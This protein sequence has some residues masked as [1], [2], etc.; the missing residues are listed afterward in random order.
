MFPIP[1]LKRLEVCCTRGS[2]RGSFKCTVSGS[3]FPNLT[4]LLISRFFLPETAD[5]FQGVT[6]L[7]SLEVVDCRRLDNKFDWI[8]SNRNLTKLVLY[9]SNKVDENLD[10]LLGQLSRL[11][12]LE[13]TKCRLRDYRCIAKAQSL[14]YLVL[15]SNRATLMDSSL[16]SF[17]TIPKLRSLR[18]SKAVLLTDNGMSSL[19]RHPISSLDLDYCNMN[20]D[21]I[22]SL[23]PFL[24]ELRLMEAPRM[25]STI[26]ATFLKLTSLT[27][28]NRNADIECYSPL[29][30]LTNLTNL[31]VHGKTQRPKSFQWLS[32]LKFMRTLRL[33]SVPDIG[34]RSDQ[35]PMEFLSNLQRLELF[36]L[37]ARW[38]SI[39]DWSILASLPHLSTLIVAIKVRNV[40]LHVGNFF[41]I[42]KLIIIGDSAP[43]ADPVS[44]GGGQASEG[45]EDI[46][47]RRGRNGRSIP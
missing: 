6:N 25:K 28:G 13:L 11:V 38:P 21:G 45:S 23:A 2:G 15:D 31:R 7:T 19:S 22:A 30:A 16:D 1:S 9:K 14:E 17:S 39:Y 35:P 37:D 43:Y 5:A 27:I 34:V 36:Q 40:V 47:E 3:I 26:L 29:S 4:S 10:A 24:T 41:I 46:R 42:Y 33:F 32:G 8:L 44:R 18:L 12:N 20:G